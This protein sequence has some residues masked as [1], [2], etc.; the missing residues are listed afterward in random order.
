MQLLSNCIFS[1]F[2]ANRTVEYISRVVEIRCSLSERHVGTEPRS[3][4]LK[5]EAAGCIET[6]ELPCYKTQHKHPEDC[7]LTKNNDIWNIF[8]VCICICVFKF[9]GVRVETFNS[10]HF[11]VNYIFNTPKQLT[12]TE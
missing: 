11:F 5:M 4:T 8:Q 2:L 7:H 3:V 1:L 12:Y 9:T 6:S 10:V